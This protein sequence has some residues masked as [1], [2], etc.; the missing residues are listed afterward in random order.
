[1]DKE[2]FLINYINENHKWVFNLDLSKQE[3][4]EFETDVKE[5]LHFQLC[6]ASAFFKSLINNFCVTFFKK[7]GYIK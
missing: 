1:M 5:S 7:I 4:K 2:T 6:Y 3:I